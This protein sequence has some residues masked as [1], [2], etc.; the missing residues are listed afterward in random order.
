[1]AVQD[2]ALSVREPGGRRT[3]E[4]GP[5]LGKR[6]ETSGRYCVSRAGIESI[7]PIQ[8]SA[9][10]RQICIRG[11]NRSRWFKVPVRRLKIF[12]PSLVD[13]A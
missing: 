3:L 11:F 6:S 8:A 2:V 7:S 1:M 5:P 13:V 4:A 12:R 10:R 9:E